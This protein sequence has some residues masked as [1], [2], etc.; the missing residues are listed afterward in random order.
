MNKFIA[1]ILL[2]ISLVATTQSIKA[3]TKK[4]IAIGV[5]ADGDWPGMQ[6]FIKTLRNET[7]RLLQSQYKVSLAPSNMLYSQWQPKT[8]QQNIRQMLK[9]PDIDV[10]IGIGPLTSHILASNGACPKPV[11]ATTII[12]PQLQKLPLSTQNTSGVNNLTYLVSPYVP[13]RDLEVFHNLYPFKKVGILLSEEIMQA[14]PFV[15][16]YFEQKT[17]EIGTNYQL[18]STGTKAQAV[19]NKLD[20]N[21]DLDA[22]Y[23]GAIFRMS[24][25]ET[26]KLIAGIN[27]K[28][29]PSFSLLGG[30]DVAKGVLA[31]IAPPSNHQRISRRVALNI[32]R[33]LAGENPA[34]F[35]VHMSFKENLVINMATVRAI[36]FYPTWNQ[37]SEATLLHEE[38]QNI[39][40]RLS[41]KQVA[42]EAIQ[43]NLELKVAN[44]QVN[45]GLNNV[46]QAQSNLH[47]QLELSATGRMIDKDRAASSFGNQPEYAGIGS[48]TFTQVLV[49]PQ[50][51]GNIS[52][53]RS[54]QQS[55]QHQRQ[56]TRLDIILQA[57]QG[58]LNM[59]QAKSLERIQKDNLR[60]T[61][62][63]L[64]LART[65]K[66]VGYSGP[67][68]LYRWESQ[69][70][71]SKKDLIDAQS[72]LKLA[73]MNLNQL[74]NRP[75]NEA[76]T[77]Q[78]IDLNN[79]SLVIANP[80]IFKYIDNPRKFSI[81]GD[82]LVDEG[83]ANLPEIK[84]IDAAI[85]A[86]KRLRM[87]NKKQFFTP[88]IALQAGADYLFYRGGEGV[89]APA[90]SIPGP[91]GPVNLSD[92]FSSPDKIN[93][94][95]GLKASLPLLT[96]GKRQANWQKTNIE[97][98]K[99][100]TQKQQLI[101]KLKQR[102]M[103]TLMLSRA[104][105]S[106]IQLTQAAEKAASKNFDLVQDAY[107]K[108]V[109]S[110]I[111]LID[112]QNAAI[113]AGQFSANAVYEFIIRLLSLERA[114][115][116][117]YFMATAEQQNDYFKRLETYF[118]GK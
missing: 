19:L 5:V 91:N 47:P 50:A 80:E 48:L 99:L 117:Y 102:I 58:Y 114:T 33:I 73:A 12:N 10:V 77:P 23:L 1:G 72:R 34:N 40:R 106:S 54:L 2:T 44:Q 52:I 71:L 92:N 30:S 25:K 93:W 94:Q 115:G 26:Q 88:T 31:G 86:Q 16:T 101:L 100:E 56:Q 79:A 24:D 60:L 17:K 107:S 105:Y 9:R 59:L 109:V 37:L 7:R 84:Q 98:L 87:V 89:G 97:I 90:I 42:K 81:L 27:A 32:Q 18:I 118:Q 4:T 53:Q 68:D 96:G 41:L 95:V 49:S 82:F 69:I 21:K 64:E 8:I 67:S 111:Q 83:I 39:Q 55:R 110:V 66:A 63:N 61:R 113:K 11:I 35:S 103:S 45:S 3:Q 78:E 38:K 85:A 20:K 65:R 6:R 104:A 57:T 51:R 62:R 14:M 108:G 43:A 70:A 13:K 74:L 112:A 29:L 116:Y 15:K 46:H 75:V 36:D 28:R 76:F 22:I